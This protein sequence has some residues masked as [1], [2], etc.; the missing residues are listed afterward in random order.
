MRNRQDHFSDIDETERWCGLYED[1][2]SDSPAEKRWAIFQ[3]YARKRAEMRLNVC[4]NLIGNYDHLNVL[5]IACG[6]GHY[7]LMATQRGCN[8]TGM[9]LSF[10]M[11]NIARSL[12]ERHNQPAIFIQGDIRHLPFRKGSFDAIFCVGIL[13]YFSNYEAEKTI[14][15]LPVLLRPGGKLILQ[16]IRLDILTWFRSRLPKWVPRPFRVPGPLYP[17][18]AWRI[19]RALSVKTLHLIKVVEMKKLGIVPF[20]TIYLFQNDK[21]PAGYRD[22]DV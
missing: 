15:Q 1:S 10:N 6:G 16:T 18:K 21:H 9:D 13:S 3:D 7:G 4:V 8:W 12:L 5:D 22:K 17:R 11:L 2:P 20:Q 19:I 14:R